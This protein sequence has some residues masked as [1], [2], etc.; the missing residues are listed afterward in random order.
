MGVMLLIFTPTPYMDAT[1]SW[2]FRNRWHRILVGA[3]GMIVEVFFRR[4][5][6]HCLGENGTRHD[7]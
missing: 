2:G 6:G 3:A 1:A 4:H 7:P 5:S